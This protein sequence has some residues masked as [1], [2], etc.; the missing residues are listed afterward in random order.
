MLDILFRY[1]ILLF[2]PLSRKVLS[3]QIIDLIDENRMVQHLIAFLSLYVL[4]KHMNEKWNFNKIL[5]YSVLIYGLF[6]MTTKMDLHINIMVIGLLLV[7]YLYDD[8]C[9]KKEEQ[10]KTDKNIENI[11]KEM[12]NGRFIFG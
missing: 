3:K 7:Y 8:L 1:Y 4:I 9:K 12:R 5:S 11:S 2:T 10:L 6:I